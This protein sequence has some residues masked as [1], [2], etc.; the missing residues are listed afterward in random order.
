MDQSCSSLHT[1]HSSSCGGGDGGGGF[2]LAREDYG[3]R[4]DDAFPACAF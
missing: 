4:V 3:G 2:F 1:Y